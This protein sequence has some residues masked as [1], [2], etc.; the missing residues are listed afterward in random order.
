MLDS[1][2]EKKF[3]HVTVKFRIG[4]CQKS[5]SPGGHSPNLKARDTF[6]LS[7]QKFDSGKFLQILLGNSD[8]LLDISIRVPENKT[9]T[10]WL[11]YLIES[12]F[13]LPIHSC[14]RNVKMNDPS[15]MSISCEN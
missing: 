1:E 15:P 8:P 9:T 10:F 2:T 5:Y 11:K 6:Q 3:E 13:E 12:S 4:Y 7:F 14:P